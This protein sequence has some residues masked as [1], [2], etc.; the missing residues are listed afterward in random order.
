MKFPLMMFWWTVMSVVCI[1]KNGMMVL[2][3]KFQLKKIIFW[4]SFCILLVYQYVFI[5]PAIEDKYWVLVNHL[6][7]LILNAT[8]TLKGAI[9]CFQK[10]NWKIHRNSS[11]KIF[12]HENIASN[13]LIFFFKILYISRPLSFVLFFILF[14]Q[15][16]SMNLS[17]KQWHEIWKILKTT[18]MK[19]QTGKCT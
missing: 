17:I 14:F 15:F 19:Y 11:L 8:V 5:D 7:Q 6:L 3:K 13:S 1:K 16:I 12:E 9:I 2:L 4:L 18:T 10:V